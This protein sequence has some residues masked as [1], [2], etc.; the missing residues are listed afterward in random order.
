M[1]ESNGEKEMEKERRETACIDILT[2]FLF[3]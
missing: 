3:K 1:E 2:V